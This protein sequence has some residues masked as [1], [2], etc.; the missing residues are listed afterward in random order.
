[1]IEFLI[2]KKR[3]PPDRKSSG[4]FL[5]VVLTVILNRFRKRYSYSKNNNKN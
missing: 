1:M 4:D 5:W 2:F 3:K